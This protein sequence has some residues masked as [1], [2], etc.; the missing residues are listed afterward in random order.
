MTIPG[1]QK[2]VIL[3]P[4]TTFKIG[5]PAEYFIVVKNSE[6][7]SAAVAEASSANLPW[8]ILGGGSDLL[9]ADAGVKGLVIKSELRDIIFDEKLRQVRAGSGVQINALINQCFRHGLTGLEFAIGV[10]ATVGGAVWA[11]L[12]ARGSEIADVLLSATV[13]TPT[14]QVIEMSQADCQFSYRESI[15]KHEQYAILEATFQLASGDVVT[16]QNK[17]KELAAIRKDTQDVSQQCA[18][19]VFRN[20]AEQTDIAAAKLIDDLGLK[21]MRIGGAQVSDRH[22]NFIINTGGATADEVV[23]LISYVKQQVRDKAGVQLM[24]EI[25]YL[26]F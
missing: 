13:L 26:G 21:G 5:G 3:A 8:H 16:M 15:F 18:G 25:E 12:G 20:P 23:Q 17:I 9:V 11:N 2:D 10:P 19:C 6:E 7:L 1:L 14:G 22:A 4:Y 24:E